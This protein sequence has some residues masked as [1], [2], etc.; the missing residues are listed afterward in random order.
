LVDGRYLT[1]LEGFPRS[2]Q[3]AIFEADG[4]RCRKSAKLRRTSKR[5]TLRLL[6]TVARA[7]ARTGRPCAMNG[8][9]LRPTTKS[10]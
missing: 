7:L 3:R 1:H 2:V 10:G 4:H 9:V 5:T 8:I 6:T